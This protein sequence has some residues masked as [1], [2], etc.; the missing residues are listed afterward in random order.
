VVLKTSYTNKAMA[1]YVRIISWVHRHCGIN[2]NIE[3]LSNSSSA[4]RVS[5]EDGHQRCPIEN[6]VNL[7]L[8]PWPNPPPD[9][10]GH[11]LSWLRVALLDIGLAFP[12]V[13]LSGVWFGFATW[14]EYKPKDSKF[15]IP[16]GFL[17]GV[18]TL[19]LAF[20]WVIRFA[21]RA[22]ILTIIRMLLG[23][24]WGICFVYLFNTLFCPSLSIGIWRRGWQLQALCSV[25]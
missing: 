5:L 20:H 23:I 13:I 10:P 21:V 9:R 17:F 22:I 25:H 14:T 18:L 8:W 3:Y 24:T 7:F 16:F 2:K 1:I 6:E 15:Q 4:P 19:F 12:I 11:R